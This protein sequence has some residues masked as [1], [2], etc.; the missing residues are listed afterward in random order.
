MTTDFV[1]NIKGGNTFKIKATWRRLYKGKK[2]SGEGK[3]IWMFWVVGCNTFLVRT[4]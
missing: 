3:T 2:W 1:E 4:L